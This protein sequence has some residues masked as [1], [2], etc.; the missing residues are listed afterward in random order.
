M[1]AR[2]LANSSP[3]SA[4]T[5][6]GFCAAAALGAMLVALHGHGAGSAPDERWQLAVT[7][8][9]DAHFTELI[10]S[11]YTTFPGRSAAE[12]R[13][14]IEGRATDGVLGRKVPL[15]EIGVRRLA[16]QQVRGLSVTPR[17]V[18]GPL[19]ARLRD[20]IRRAGLA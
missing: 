16:H 14:A 10:G 1:T 20:R 11:A 4:S 15:R 8:G 2:I 3:R 9:S 6:F 12:L 13:V 7:G 19:A 17:K 5:I 18:L